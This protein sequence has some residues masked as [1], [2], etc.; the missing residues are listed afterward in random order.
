MIE[1]S[2]QKLFEGRCKV[3][4][5]DIDNID[6]IPLNISKSKA[7]EILAKH[8]NIDMKDVIVIGDEANDVDMFKITRNSYCMA[9]SDKSIQKQANSVVELVEDAIRIEIEKIV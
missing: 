1:S 4:A 7:V 8:Y 5:N 2:L 6:F 3:L 9:H